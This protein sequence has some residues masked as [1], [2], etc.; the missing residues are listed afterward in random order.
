MDAERKELHKKILVNLLITLLAI[1]FV[2]FALPGLLRFFLPMIIA[3]VIALIANPIVHFLE[4]R[5]RIVRKHGSAI[6]IVSVV[7]LVA[8]A[9]VVLIN[10]IAHQL[11]SFSKGL[12]DFYNQI[13]VS[14]DVSLGELHEK[15]SFIP[16]SIQEIIGKNGSRV[17]EMANSFFQSAGNKVLPSVG[18]MA[19]SIIDMIVLTVL[20]LMLSY[21]LVARPEI[22]KEPVR[23]YMPQSVKDFWN[24]AMNTC[25]R[26]V[27]AYFKACFKI[28]IV[29]FLILVVIY[30]GV[31]RAKYAVMLA[32][33]TAFMDFLPF[34]GTGIVLTPWALYCILT[35][36][37]LDAVILALTYVICLLVHRLLEP[38]LISD[39]VEISPLAILVSMFIGYRLIGMLG[40]ILGI[41]VGM[42][43]LSFIEEGVFSNQIKGIRL[44]IEDI[45]AYR[46]Y[47]L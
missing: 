8:L 35:G 25:I 30:V 43:L 16:D 6:V 38:K 3:W 33:L 12:P 44:L 47:K 7:L 39:S 40:L 18:S 36:G 13:I 1:L 11:I 2:I 24:M 46:K 19:S 32:L 26:A 9:I 31:L 34:F 4:N 28:G 14:L 10:F 23:K 29:I 17:K 42:V 45:N 37:Y 27:G 20:T 41:P 21:F 15:F 5:I 22:I